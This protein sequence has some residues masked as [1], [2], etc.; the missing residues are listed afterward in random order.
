MSAEDLLQKAQKRLASSSGG[1]FSFGSSSSKK[2]EAR[3][4][5]IAA[6]NQFKISKRW[7]ESGDCFFQAAKVAESLDERDDAMND[8]W[9][10]AKSYKK[11]N[12]D[13]AVSNLERAI[14][15]LIEKGRFRQAADRKKEI[16]ELY[17]EGEV[18]LVKA[19]DAYEQAGD[20]YAQEDA[21]ATA[22]AMYKTVAELAVAVDP[23]DWKKAIERFEQVAKASLS[24]NLTKYSVKE[25][26]L[27]AGLCRLATGDVVA[28]RLALDNYVSQDP[29]FSQTREFKFLSAIADAYEKSDKDQYATEVKEYDSL[30]KLDS[31]KTR[32]LLQIKNAIP[33][34]EDLT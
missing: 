10:A 27:K 3:D 11:C 15:I 19:L 14:Q 23:P 12:P 17:Q 22:N 16:G 1:L 8:F 13:L 31:W 18:D 28:T 9:N 29:G 30:T 7:Q 24:S 34:L 32:V 21:H 5:F 4:L 6:A 33:D 25:Y 2:E 20:W 26:Y